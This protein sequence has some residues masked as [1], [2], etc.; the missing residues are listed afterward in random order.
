MLK[1]TNDRV[2]SVQTVKSAKTDLLCDEL[3]ELL[4]EMPDATIIRMRVERPFKE[5]DD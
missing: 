1:E 3:E 2:M 4:Q 5:G